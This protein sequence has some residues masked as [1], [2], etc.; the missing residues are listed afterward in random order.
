MGSASVVIGFCSPD[1]ARRQN[2]T[3]HISQSSRVILYVMTEQDWL[4]ER[5]EEHRTRLRAVA[6]RML[7]SVGE[8]DDAVQEAWLRLS[9]QE[10]DEIENLAGWLTTVVGRVALNMLRARASRPERPVGVQMP[11]PIVDRPDEPNPEHEALLADS[12]GLALLVVL[13]TLTPA[14][15]LAFVL[16]DMFGL[17][18]EEIAPIVERSVPATRKLASRARRRVRNTTPPEDTDLTAQREVVEAYLAA[19]REGDF[20]ALVAVLDPDVVSR[21]DFGTGVLREVRGAEAVAG[22]ALTYST[23]APFGRLALVNG[24][25]GIVGARKDGEPIAVLAFT[26]RDRKVVELDVLADR[27]RLRELDLAVLEG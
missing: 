1:P 26:V 3:G 10:A 15:R 7:G 20:D 4:A 19:A 25:P 21:A 18:F 9:R 12:V 22:Q 14:E 17:P 13:E 8:A 6:Y 24:T 5:F 27:A 16:H 23:L 11:E 2:V